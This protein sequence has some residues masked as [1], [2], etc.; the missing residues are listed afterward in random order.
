[1]ATQ[2]ADSSEP[3]VHKD[4]IVD[5]AQ[6]LYAEFDSV[7]YSKPLDS[8]DEEYTK[9]I[10]MIWKVADEETKM[11]WEHVANYAIKYLCI[12]LDQ[13]IE[14]CAKEMTVI[15]D[16]EKVKKTILLLDESS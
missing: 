14:S 7:T 3:D 11:R 2:E 9:M 12:K 15:Y 4:N 10:K 6:R 8:S 5:L 13:H 1:M 16:G